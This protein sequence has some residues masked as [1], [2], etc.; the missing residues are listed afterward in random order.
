MTSQ[1][2]PKVGEIVTVNGTLRADKDFGG[3][4]KYAVIVEEAAIK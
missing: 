3:G 1:D 4:Y 2:V